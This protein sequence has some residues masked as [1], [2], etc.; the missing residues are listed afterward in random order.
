MYALI[1]RPDGRPLIDVAS[2]PTLCPCFP[3]TCRGDVVG[4]KLANGQRCK[5]C[6]PAAAA[7]AVSHE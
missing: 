5:E 1:P 7:E 3:G 6:M 4:G 2:P